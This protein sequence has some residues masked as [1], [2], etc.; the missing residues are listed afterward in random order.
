M[1]PSGQSLTKAKKAAGMS[2]QSDGATGMGEFAGEI[3]ALPSLDREPST[4]L[5]RNSHTAQTDSTVR[6]GVP[7]GSVFQ[8]RISCSA[9]GLLRARAR[10]VPARGS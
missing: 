1:L 8:A 4:H 10:T 3:G 2:C 6:I 7:V 5:L 9:G